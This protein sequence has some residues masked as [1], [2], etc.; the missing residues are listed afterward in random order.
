MI[1]RF[2]CLNIRSLLPKLDEFT[3]T[4]HM[5]KHKFA[6]ICL[7]E[8]WLNGNILNLANIKGYKSY[9]KVGE[10]RRG[11]GVSIYIDESVSCKILDDYNVS[12]DCI[13]CLFIQCHYRNIKFLIGCIYRPPNGDCDLCMN[14]NYG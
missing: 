2:L 8:T 12:S 4:L 6:V 11:G 7:T 10:G 5:M 1:Y 3:T 9:H 14:H 13:E